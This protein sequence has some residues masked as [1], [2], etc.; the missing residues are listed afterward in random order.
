MVTNIES[1]K[2]Q[3][4][5]FIASLQHE[6]VI[7]AFENIAQQFKLPKYKITESQL[8]TVSKEDIAYFNRP[9]RKSISIE[10]LVFEQKWQPIDENEMNDIVKKLDI[11]EPIEL[12]ISQLKP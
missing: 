2:V 10:E 6:E 8:S 7:S 1:R 3:L 4:I 11:Q 9:I 12:L 5:S